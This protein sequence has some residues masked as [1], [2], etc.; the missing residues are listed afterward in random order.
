LTVDGTLIEA[1]ASQKS[2][3]RKDGCDDRDGAN[4]GCVA[5]FG[6]PGSGPGQCRT[7]DFR[8]PISVTGVSR[9]ESAERHTSDNGSYSIS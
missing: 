1:W 3:L 8:G 2:F 7:A 6:E 4:G 5:Q 9:E